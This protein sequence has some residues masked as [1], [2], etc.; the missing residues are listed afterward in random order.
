MQEAARRKYNNYK[1]LNICD[2]PVVIQLSYVKRLELEKYNDLYPGECVEDSDVNYTRAN[3]VMDGREREMYELCRLLDETNGRQKVNMGP[4]NAFGDF[5]VV[6]ST[7]IGD[8]RT[9]RYLVIV[10]NKGAIMGISDDAMV[11]VPCYLR[12]RVPEPEAETTIKTDDIIQG[13]IDG[14][15]GVENVAH[16]D[17][18][19]ARLRVKVKDKSVIQVS[20][21]VQI[22]YG[23][24]ADVY[25]TQIRNVL[26]MK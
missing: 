20:D 16:V 11:E 4:F 21:C 23:A 12:S 24:K 2:I 1:I 15:G 8:N 10:E 17:A 22:V 19:F 3:M 14:L 9:D 5:I 25:K 18:C 26:G 13:M 6:V 7:S